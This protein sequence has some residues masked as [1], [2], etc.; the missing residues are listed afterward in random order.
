MFMF[1][2]PAVLLSPMTILLMAAL[3]P[4][5]ILLVKVYRMDTIEKEP[6]GLIFRLVLAGA[7]TVIPAGFLEGI[8]IGSILTPLVG[9]ENIYLYNF[10]QYFLV[11]GIAEEGV[12]HFALRKITWCSP[13]FNYRFDA[14]VY[15]VSVSLGFAAA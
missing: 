3:I 12:K 2:A 14:V 4:P 1:Y 8:G 11:V 13:E 5:F 6:K 9:K 7:L 15:A 10:L